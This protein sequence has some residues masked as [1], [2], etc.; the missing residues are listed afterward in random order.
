[1]TELPT[2]PLTWPRNTP[3]RNPLQRA[4]TSRPALLLAFVGVHLALVWLGLHGVG[5]PMGDIP[6][7]YWPWVDFMLK[8]H[9]YLG[10]D[11]SWV[12]PYPNLLFVLAPAGFPGM[13][14]Q[15]AWLT[16]AT[17]IDVLSLATL[18]YWNPQARGVAG[19]AVNR[20]LYAGWLWALGLFLLGPVGISRLDTIS[21]A[22]AVLAVTAWLN[23]KPNIAAVWLAV[24]TWIKVWPF[25]ILGALIF[26]AKSKSKV[27]LWGIGA[28]LALLVLGLL[29][30]DFRSVLG[31][32]FEQSDRGV[33]IESP[34][35]AWWLW[36]G[37]AGVQGTGLYYD[38]GLQTFQVQGDGTVLISA[39]L[40][41]VMYGAVAI[42]FALS[43]FAQRLANTQEQLNQVFAWTSL[44]AVLDLIAFNKVG[45]PQYYGW[46]LIPAIIFSLVRPQ[47]WRTVLVWILGLLALTGYIYPVIY[48]AILSANPLATAV[49]SGRNLVLLGLLVLANMRLTGLTSKKP[50][51]LR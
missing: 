46:L 32:V 25:A 51:Q 44:T 21:V 43:W 49:L 13:D 47:L 2:G 7:A 28:G 10:L 40:G 42:T 17:C 8:T 34:W 48:D 19:V 24:A 6:N 39:L 29:I 31:F 11:Q 37:V 16:M 12:Y 35:A 14:Y 38:M 27:A 9:H 3:T 45:S 33:Q 20:R 4:L 5:Q 23:L 18:L 36:L 26:T 50:S 22:I 41:P 1:V 15:T 30:G